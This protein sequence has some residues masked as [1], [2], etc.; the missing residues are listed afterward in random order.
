MYLETLNAEFAQGYTQGVI[1]RVGDV[2]DFPL[3]GLHIR[4]SAKLFVSPVKVFCFRR[5]VNSALRLEACFMLTPHCAISFWDYFP[6][7]IEVHEYMFGM[8]GRVA[9]YPWYWKGDLILA[10]FVSLCLIKKKKPTPSVFITNRTL[11]VNSLRKPD[12]QLNPCEAWYMELESI[13]WTACSSS[14]PR[15]LLMNS[16]C[17]IT[18]L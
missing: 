15:H 13:K 6:L 14:I 18:L 8:P 2:W 4:A 10:C 11:C 1:F 7:D 5:E 17:A 12:R 16:F 3:S 9:L